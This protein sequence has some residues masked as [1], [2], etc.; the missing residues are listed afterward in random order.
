VAKT[1]ARNDETSGDDRAAFAWWREFADE[2]ADEGS[3]AR[4]LVYALDG[5]VDQLE[6]ADG[7]LAAVVRGSHPYRVSLSGSRSAPRWSCD[8]P[9]G[10]ER[11]FCKHC[12]AV[13]LVATAEDSEPPARVPAEIDAV[14]AYLMSLDQARLVDLVVEQTGRDDAFRERLAVRAAA[15]AGATIDVRERRQRLKRAFGTGRFVDYRHAPD[16][17]FGVNEA[18]DELEE[19]LD[20]GFAI[21]V[22]EL[23]EYAHI[24]AEQAIQHIDDSDGCITAIS[25]RLGDVHVRACTDAR[26]DPVALARR[27]VKLELAGELDTFHRA[28]LGYARAL[29]PDGIDEYR[30]LIEPR[31][32]ALAPGEDWSHERFRVRHARVGVALAARDPDELI[33][34]KAN[35]LRLPDDYAEI[36]GLLAEMGRIDD[37][38]RWCEQ[39]LTDHADRTWQL[40]PLREL[41]A[42]L[43]RDRGDTEAALEV[44]RIAFEERPSLDAYR[45]LVREA[46]A[47]GEGER[48]R[49]DALVSLQRTLAAAEAAGSTAH[50]QHLSATIIEVLLFEGRVDDAWR[51]ATER[52]CDQRLWMQLARA[53]ESEHPEDAIPIYEREVEALIGKKNDGGYRDAVKLM[54]HLESLHIRLESRDAFASFV[55]RIRATHLRKTN[56]MRRVD[57]KGW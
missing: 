33:A 28:A 35:D 2:L 53:R 47:A 34:V 44:F 36:A 43:H 26:M 41:L 19:L 40:A 57:A 30:R 18:L 4:G 54:A 49:V 25:T 27:L 20:A 16:W 39:G 50:A 15:A 17:A 56:L 38:I 13:A 10:V 6:I 7:S 1:V 32:A 8:C 22:V 42:Q 45:R 3:L 24:R 5:R 9:V 21:E 37:A 11:M 52:D 31:F 14:R 46:D 55:E 23:V 51:T 12:V 48:C 29:G